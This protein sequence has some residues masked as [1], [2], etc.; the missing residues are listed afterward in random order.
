MFKT[1]RQAFCFRD[2][3]ANADQTDDVIV[4]ITKG[5]FGGAV[6]CRRT[7][8]AQ[9]MLVD[10]ADDRRP[11]FDHLHIVTIEG[12]CDDFGV[13][14][15]IGLTKGLAAGLRSHDLGI[16]PIF[17]NE[18]RLSI[19]GIDSVWNVVDNGA[20]KSALVGQGTLS[21]YFLRYIGASTA[22]AFELPIAIKDRNAANG[23]MIGLPIVPYLD[24]AKIAEQPTILQIIK[25]PPAFVIDLDQE[26]RALLSKGRRDI[27]AR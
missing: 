1:I 25:M 24:V 20:Q 15:K 9:I 8:L 17:Q 2:V 5:N 26:F 11:A 3:A 23:D 7:I 16:E 12:L 6:P 14:V 21:F 10:F 19:L 13:V 22:I 27:R 18:S 4:R